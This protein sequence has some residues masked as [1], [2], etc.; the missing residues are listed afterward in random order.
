M[1]DCSLERSDVEVREA[2]ELSTSTLLNSRRTATHL[3]RSVPSL[4][5]RNL[6]LGRPVSRRGSL[7]WVL[8]AP[9]M[10]KQM[11][12]FVANVRTEYRKQFDLRSPERTP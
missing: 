2:P 1:R 4:Y 8:M 7:G 12:H 3:S 9:L 5:R 10:R 6:A 11:L